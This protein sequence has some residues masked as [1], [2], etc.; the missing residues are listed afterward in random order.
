LYDCEKGNSKYT[1]SNNKLYYSGSKVGTAK[2]SG[3]K[4]TFEF[5]SDYMKTSF[6]VA[7]QYYGLN[8]TVEEASLSFSGTLRKNTIKNGKIKGK[9]VMVF[10]DTDGGGGKKSKINPAEAE[11][12][13][14]P[15]PG[16]TY[17]FEYSGKFTAE[18]Q[19]RKGRSLK[20]LHNREWDYGDI[21]DAFDIVTSLAN[22]K[23]LLINKISP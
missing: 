15:E 20:E 10:E 1:V 4:I 16:I 11:P 23:L 8:V 7:F 12:S 22:S 2:K 6:E 13:I 17:T 19:K 9:I 21:I 18:K 5:D 3:K 14:T